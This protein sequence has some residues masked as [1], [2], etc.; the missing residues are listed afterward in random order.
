[1]TFELKS[2]HSNIFKLILE[3]LEKYTKYETYFTF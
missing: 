3:Y 2:L 1:M